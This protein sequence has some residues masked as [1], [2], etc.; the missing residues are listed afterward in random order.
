MVALKKIVAMRV[1][2][3]GAR[4][5]YCKW[6]LC[7]LESTVAGNMPLLSGF[8]GWRVFLLLVISI[9]WIIRYYTL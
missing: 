7:G 2:L 8:T 5:A 9:I 1:Y 6:D 4:A 3:R